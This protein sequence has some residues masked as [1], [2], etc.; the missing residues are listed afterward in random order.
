MELRVCNTCDEEKELNDFYRRS[1]SGNYTG[2]CRQCKIVRQAKRY[3]ANK[4]HHN[5]LCKDRYDAHGRFV[6]YGITLERYREMEAEQDHRC[7]LCRTPDPGGKGVW[8]IDHAHKTGE[9]YKVARY[10]GARVRGLLCH[11]CNQAL[12]FYES[13]LD[14]VGLERIE[15]YLERG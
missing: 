7:A 4:L 5:K 3:R 15:Q 14:R 2:E 10:E 11:R 6:R 13:L 8:H 12:G 1:D 9:D